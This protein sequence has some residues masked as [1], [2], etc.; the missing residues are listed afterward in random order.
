M[1]LMTS[2][3]LVLCVKLSIFRYLY[4]VFNLVLFIMLSLMKLFPV[5]TGWL[6]SNWNARIALDAI[7]FAVKG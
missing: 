6:N 4:F 5:T 3:Y 7:S 2:I 1:N